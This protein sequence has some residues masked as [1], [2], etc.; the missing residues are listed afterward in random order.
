MIR[1]TSALVHPEVFFCAAKLNRKFADVMGKTL[2]VVGYFRWMHDLR[3][4]PS[5]ITKLDPKN[6]SVER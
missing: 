3:G 5:I 2:Y 6:L 4:P 1:I